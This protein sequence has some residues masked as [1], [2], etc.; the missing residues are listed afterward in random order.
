MLVRSILFLLSAFSLLGQREGYVLDSV[1]VDGNH[2]IPSG[3]II[4]TLGLKIGRPLEKEAF[5]AARN[6]LNDTGAFDLVTYG[7]SFSESHYNVVYHVVEIRPFVPLRFEDLPVQEKA[8]RAAL[9]EQEPFFGGDRIPPVA[10]I[11]DRYTKAIQRLIGEPV[12]SRFNSEGPDDLAVIFR[13]PKERPR[14]AEVHFEGTDAL[15]EGVLLRA[16]SQ[17]AIGIS[18]TEEALRL[19]M[20]ASIRPLYEAR[21]RIRVAFPKIVSAPSTRVDGVAVTVTVNEGP[22]YNFGSIKV[23]GAASTETAGWKTGEI[24]NFDEVNAGLERIYKRYRATGYL[25]VTGSVAREVHDDSHTVDLAVTIDLGTQYRFGKLDI[26]GLN[27]LTEPEIRKAWG[28][29]EGKPYQSDYADAFLAR[30]RQEGVFDNLGKTRSE[31]KVDDASRTVDIT[32]YFS[33]ASPVPD[34]RRRMP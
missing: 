2:E 34:P 31:A 1:Q 25:K 13:P 7:Y 12:I 22:V 20:D 17:S 28:A 19:N 4:A 15:P 26:V 27:L 18:F 33:G 21:G 8:L 24:A 10:A 16:L 3:K 30:L 9:S 29:M 32:L 14:I 11:V 23:T 6:R 5:E